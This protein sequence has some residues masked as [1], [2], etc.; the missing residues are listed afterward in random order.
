MARESK[1]GLMPEILTLD[2]KIVS[3]GVAKPGTVKLA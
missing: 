3:P 1:L 2:A